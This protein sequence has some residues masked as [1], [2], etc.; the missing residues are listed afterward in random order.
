MTV[1]WIALV[2]VAVCFF[3]FG[4]TLRGE[5]DVW[6]RSPSSGETLDFSRKRMGA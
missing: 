5:I 2:A 6:R 3:L 4:W 1:V